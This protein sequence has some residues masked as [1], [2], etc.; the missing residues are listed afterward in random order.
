M[1]L[2]KRNK[3]DGESKKEESNN[4]IIKKTDNL[5]RVE[6][7]SSKRIKEDK[8]DERKIEEI[9]EKISKNIEITKE[10]QEILSESIKKKIGN[11][12]RKEKKTNHI[13]GQTNST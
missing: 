6:F 2:R 1:K 8:E 4:K 7:R 9:L 5:I 13:C 11:K 3:R 10:E 12:N